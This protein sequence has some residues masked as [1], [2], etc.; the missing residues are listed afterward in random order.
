M[1]ELTP[2]EPTFEVTESIRA[3]AEKFIDLGRELDGLETGDGPIAPEDSAAVK[4]AIWFAL[5]VVDV[6]LATNLLT[7]GSPDVER[8][9]LADVLA[10]LEKEASDEEHRG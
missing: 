7:L 6:A 3:T 4:G 2:L 9:G 10:A 8:L 1:S 5:G